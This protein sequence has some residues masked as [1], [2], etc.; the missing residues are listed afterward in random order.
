VNS[1]ITPVMQKYA[2]TMHDMGPGKSCDEAATLTIKLCD[3]GAGPYVVV[4]ARKWSFDDLEDAEQTFE[5]IRQV[6]RSCREA[7]E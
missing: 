3:S 6:V 4:S 2:M 7:K 1:K 5:L